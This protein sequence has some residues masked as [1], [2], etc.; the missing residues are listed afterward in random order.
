M[1]TKRELLD[2]MIHE[3]EVAKHLY[4]KL[5]RRALAY[6]PTSGQ[7]STLELLRYLSYLG[8]GMSAYLVTGKD[9]AYETRHRRS[10]SMPARSFPR[11]MDRQ[12]R[13]LRKLLGAIPEREFETRKVTLP[14]GRRGKLGSMLLETSLKWLVGY[15]MQLFLYA[16]ATG[17]SKL[18]TSDC[19]LGKSRKP[20]R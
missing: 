1:I 16:K 14:W 11:A 9:S 6:R 3:C 5:P 12:I 4:R 19:W 17:A 18:G 20:K 13:E 7:R 8:I 10:L 15:R 2:S